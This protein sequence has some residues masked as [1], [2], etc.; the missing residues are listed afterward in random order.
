MKNRLDRALLLCLCLTL[1]FAGPAAAQTA[2]PPAPAQASDGGVTPILAASN[3]D[4][5]VSPCTDFFHY[6]N[7]GWIARN[8]IPPGFPLWSRLYEL[9]RRSQDSIR[10]ILQKAARNTTA[11]PASVEGKI[12]AFY[13]SCMDETAAEAQGLQPI[14]PELD[15]I[16]ALSGLAAAVG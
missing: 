7:G 2:N 1:A 8:P 13:A 10:T 5:Q 12:G 15:R 14:R 6:A 3:L 4:L 16:D 9:G 11:A